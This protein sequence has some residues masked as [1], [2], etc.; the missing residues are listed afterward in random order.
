LNG[1]QA[2]DPADEQ[3]GVP[4][5]QFVPGNNVFGNR[6]PKAF[7]LK[8]LEETDACS[9]PGE[10]G[11]YL[12]QNGLTHTT[13]TCFRKQRASGALDGPASQSAGAARQSRTPATNK[14]SEETRRLM[15]LERENRKL[16]R[17][18]EQAEVIID[19]QKKVA[20]LLEI[21]LDEPPT[22]RS[23]RSAND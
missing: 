17:Q 18:L 23:N 16:R 9:K 13:L 11:R 19:I 6:Y 1:A 8:V 10:L 22:R 3:T 12:R 2:G 5:P 4:D 7:K 15:E 20:R 14:K 21:P